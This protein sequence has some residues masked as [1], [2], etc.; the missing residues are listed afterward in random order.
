MTEDTVPVLDVA[1]AIENG[2]KMGAEIFCAKAPRWPRLWFF[3]GEL[4][5]WIGGLMRWA[6]FPRTP[7]GIFLVCCAP[8]MMRKA[9]AEWAALPA[10]DKAISE[11]GAGLVGLMAT[12]I[13]G[14]K[15]P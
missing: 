1:A 11:L 2:F 5:L 3:L 4:V 6:G 15:K 9:R 10:R 8:I 7:Y 14:S 13:R 12:V